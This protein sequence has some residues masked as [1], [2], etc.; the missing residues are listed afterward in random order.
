MNNIAVAAKTSNDVDEGFNSLLDRNTELQT[1][2]A[3]CAQQIEALKN[4][5]VRLE[6]QRESENIRR[7]RAVLFTAIA[8]GATDCV[9]FPVLLVLLLLA[10]VL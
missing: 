10:S 6:E 8:W 2:I 4:T 9:Y 7:L 5:T 1:Q 3:C